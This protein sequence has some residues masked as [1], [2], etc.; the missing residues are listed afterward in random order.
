MIEP[1]FSDCLLHVSFKFK[2]FHVQLSPH[3]S[4]YFLRIII[5]IIVFNLKKNKKEI[6]SFTLFG[7]LRTIVHGQKEDNYLFIYIP[8]NFIYNFFL[9]F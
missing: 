4:K 7:P 9:V 6:T 2:I 8:L 3:P 5:N 1:Q